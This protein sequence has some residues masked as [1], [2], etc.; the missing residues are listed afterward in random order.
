MRFGAFFRE[1]DAH[2]RDEDR[3]G[4]LGVRNGDRK[5][6]AGLIMLNGSPARSSSIQNHS[7]IERPAL[8]IR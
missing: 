3:N 4:H 7:A 2:R 5:A 8:R 6:G 1:N